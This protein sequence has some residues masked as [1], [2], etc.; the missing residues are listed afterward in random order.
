MEL[1]QQLRAVGDEVLFGFPSWLVITDPLDEV[2]GLVVRTHRRDDA[3]N[4]VFLLFF[5]GVILVVVLDIPASHNLSKSGIAQHD[6]VLGDLRQVRIFLSEGKLGCRLN[7]G[8]GCRCKLGL[9]EEA[10]NVVGLVLHELGVVNERPVYASHDKRDIALVCY[11]RDVVLVKVEILDEF[12]TC[13]LLIQIDK[14][15]GA[16]TMVAMADGV[17]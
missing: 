1:I 4:L 7:S 13:I 6:V 11:F 8:L 14:V 2:L 17:V 12:S 10:V 9:N 16:D 3:F 5:V 15:K